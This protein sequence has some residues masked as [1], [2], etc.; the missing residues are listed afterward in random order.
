MTIIFELVLTLVEYPVGFTL[1]WAFTCLALRW[2]T[3]TTLLLV[4][5]TVPLFCIFLILAYI[6]IGSYFG[7]PETNLK[8]QYHGWIVFKDEGL[9]KKWTNKKLPIREAYEWYFR[10]KIDFTRSTLDVFHH[11][12]ELFRMV[13]SFSHLTEIFDG[14]IFKAWLNHDDT[15]DHGEVTPVY[16]LGNDFYYAFLSDPMFYSCGVAY[17]SSDSL[18]VAQDRKCGIVAE[19]LQLKDG[20]R[21]VDFGCGWGSWL[22]YVAKH[23]KI[24]CIGLTISQCQFDY[25][26]KR[27]KEEG[28]E[29]RVKILLL[30]YRKMT[31]DRFGEFDKITCFE[32]SEHVG[33][34]N[35]QVFCAQIKDLLKQDGLYYLQIAGLRRAWQ[36]E[37]LVWGIFM[38]KYIFPGA[39]ASCPLYWNI[40]QLERG[41]FEVHLARNQGVH[42]AHT[43]ESWYNNIVQNREE[44]VKKYGQ[45]AYR[46]HELFLAWSTMI[47]RQGSSTVWSI[48][49]AHNTPVDAYSSKTTDISLNRTEK[50]ISKE[51]YNTK[52]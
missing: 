42:Y 2:E 16:N 49:A 36:Y 1:F 29:D 47:A 6:V 11:R 52:F 45:F 7:S 35:Y 10:G 25:A 50:F 41:G 46:R 51:V 23:F 21:L 32:M 18:D 15:G 34:R 31:K 9:K 27:V 38:G 33:I 40:N 37:D 26:T 20:D 19:Q 48:I 4:F 17:D 43:I 3:Y 24:E 39:D 5:F 12:M 8:S 30:D 28:L 44:V 14:V 13:F 22:I